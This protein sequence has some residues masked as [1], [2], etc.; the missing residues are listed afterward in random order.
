[1]RIVSL[2]D[3][4]HEV[5]NPV[6]AQRVFIIIII[7]LFIYLFYVLSLLFS[8]I[9]Q[10]TKNIDMSF[11]FFFFFFFFFFFHG[12]WIWHFMWAVDYRDNLHGESYPVWTLY[13]KTVGSSLTLLC[14]MGFSIVNIWTSIL[15]YTAARLI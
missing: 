5:S 12:G 6:S 8:W 11:N 7:Y 13:L 14:R 10:Q 15:Q 4:P 1:M 9:L 2:G 3:K